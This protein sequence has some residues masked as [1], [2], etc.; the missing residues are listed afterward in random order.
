MI[1]IIPNKDFGSMGIIQKWFERAGREQALEKGQVLF[2]RGDVAL[3]PYSLKRG[4]V[5]LY[6]QDSSGREVTLHKVRPGER[7][8]EASIFSDIYHCDCIA[9]EDSIVL[10]VP[11][12]LILDALQNDPPFASALTEAFAKQVMGLRSQLELRNIRS[13]QERVLAALHLKAGGSDT[14]IRIA[15]TL[16]AFAGEIGLTHEVLYRALKELEQAGRIK[17]TGMTFEIR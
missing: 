1:E 3:G 12:T 15:G 5:R 11:K 8:A 17:R 9:D 13:A 14:E 7:F 6:R 16:K 2:L 4:Q 10:G